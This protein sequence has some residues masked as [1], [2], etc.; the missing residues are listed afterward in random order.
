VSPDVRRALTIG[1]YAVLGGALVFTRFVGLGRSFWLD[2]IVTVEVFIRAGPSEILA[3]PYIPNNHEL[4]SMLGWITTSLVGES[5]IALRLLSVVP[6]VA[7]VAL[8]TAWLHSRIHVLAG[9]VFL[10]LATASPLLLDITRQARGYGLAFAAMSVMVVCALE[11]RRAPSTWLIAGLCVAG[12]VGTC[13]L[14]IFGLAFV[15]LAAVLLVD[16]AL[17]LRAALGAGVVSLACAAW[18]APHVDDLMES[19]RQAYGVEIDIGWLATSPIDQ[20]LVPSLIW[21]DG[22]V[23]FPGLLWVPVV[24]AALVLMGA[25]PLLRDRHEALVLCSAPVVAVLF[26]WITDTRAVPR[27]LSFLLV[28]LLMLLASGIASIFRQLGRRRPPLARV[29]VS[30]VVLVLVAVGFA[31][32]GAD[33]VRLPRED[34]KNAA[35]A[36]ASSEYAAAPVYDRQIHPR[37][38]EYYLRRQVVPAAS[39]GWLQK[40]CDASEPVAI[41]VQPWVLTPAPVPCENRPGVRRYRFE[42][43]TRGNEIVVWLVPP[44]S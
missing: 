26:L 41:V 9:L 23:L 27:F 32:T 10:F 37:T 29:V 22:V 3:G 12:A 30:V 43:Y 20:I 33:V 5:E 4:F 24:V 35:A 36:I 18:Y 16:P 11:L 14:P 31:T 28:P 1:A 40:A 17:R 38:L 42:Q 21:I 2:E 44:A 34:H 25:S 8:V 19:S 7:A 39:P 13:T 6:F 15:A